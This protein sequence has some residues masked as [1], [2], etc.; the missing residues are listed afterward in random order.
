[1]K[2]QSLFRRILTIIGIGPNYLSHWG[3]AIADVKTKRFKLYWSKKLYQWADPFLFEWEDETYVAFEE[4]DWKTKKAYI[5][6]SS[7]NAWHLSTPQILLEEPYSISF[8]FIFKN[9][10]NLYMIPETHHGRGIFL[11]QIIKQ[12]GVFIT[13][14]VRTLVDNI[15]A[16][17]SVIIFSGGVYLFT[18]LGLNKTSRMNHSDNLT[19]YFSDDLL[20]G[21]FIRVNDVIIDD[22]GKENANFRNAGSVI[23]FNGE[24]YRLSQDCSKVYG[25]DINI[26]R[27][28]NLSP[29]R[30]QE[31]YVRSVIKP[32]AL[33]TTQMH[34]LNISKDTVVIDYS[35]KITFLDLV[36]SILS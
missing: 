5:V 34:T 31:E 14:K 4:Y 30:Y 17:D 10:D 26:N 18:S 24:F 27:I 35:R 13:T 8:P 12:K 15:D 28:T 36:K 33:E 19:V 22:M 25:G 29:D 7:L 32:L 9:N 23:H 3:I 16:A 2:I 1:L 20:N 21:N 11:Y 6:Y